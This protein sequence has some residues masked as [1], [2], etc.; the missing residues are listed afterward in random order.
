MDRK[1]FVITCGIACLSGAVL[2]SVMQSCASANYFAQSAI[3]NNQIVI[4]K[5]EF[6]ATEKGKSTERK[7]VLVETS[8]SSFPICIYKLNDRSFSA[9]L[10]KCTHR[11]CK[12]NPEGDY[13][14]CPCHGSEFSNKGEVV[15]P[16]AEE[17]LKT[18]QTTT[19]NDNIYIQL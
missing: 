13:L 7:F 19:D 10:T 3:T 17:N 9:L 6:I 11:G 8:M 1:E 5:T 12:L 14:V 4:K 15:H 18:F 16:P 2:S